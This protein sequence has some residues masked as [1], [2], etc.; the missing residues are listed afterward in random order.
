MH[1]GSNACQRFWA[2]N[3]GRFPLPLAEMALLT[4]LIYMFWGITPGPL[5]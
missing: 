1:D 3:G 4:A 5:P 2:A